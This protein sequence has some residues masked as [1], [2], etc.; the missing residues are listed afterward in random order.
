MLATDQYAGP[1]QSQVLG[2]M[3]YVPPLLFWQ[4]PSNPKFEGL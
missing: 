1:Q 2:K 3:F 4:G